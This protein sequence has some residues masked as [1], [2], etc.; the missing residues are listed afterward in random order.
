MEEAAE[1]TTLRIYVNLPDDFEDAVPTDRFQKYE[2]KEMLAQ[3]SSIARRA[4]AKKRIEWAQRLLI[5]FG[6]GLPESRKA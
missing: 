6:W 3:E 5:R 4:R 1:D 2:M